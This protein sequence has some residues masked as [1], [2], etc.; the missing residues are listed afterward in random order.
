M[1]RCPEICL[2]APS[3]ELQRRAELIIKAKNYTGIIVVVVDSL[4]SAAA[5]VIRLMKA[6]I[7]IFISRGGTKSYL[8]KY[9]KANV[10]GIRTLL[11]DYWDILSR[12]RAVEGPVA[13]FSFEDDLSDEVRTACKLLNIRVKHY[14]FRNES[15]A[16]KAVRKAVQD[17]AVVAVGGSVTGRIAQAMQLDYLPL[18]NAAESIEGAL[19]TAIS[20]L[21]LQK[22]E[23]RKREIINLR[24]ERYQAIFDFTHDAI[25]SIDN[26]GVVDVINPMAEK[27]LNIKSD[28]VVGRPLSSILPA[29]RLPEVLQSGKKELGSLLNV[30]NTPVY[31]NCI[32]VIVAGKIKGAVATFQD[33]KRIQASERIIRLGLHEKGLVAKYKFENILGTS[34]SIQT[35]VKIAQGYAKSN[36]TVLIYG[37]TGTG[38]ELFAQSICNESRRNNA[39]FVAINCATLDKN[40]LESEL[41]GYVAGAF[42]GALRGGKP[43]LFELA[44]TGTIFL[45]EIGELPIDIQARLLRALQEKEIRRLGSG[46]VIPIDVRVIAATNRN[47]EREVADKNFRADLFYR[48]NVLNLNIPSL[49]ERQEDIKVL[50]EF[51]FA[52]HG[53]S[54]N[55]GLELIVDRVLYLLRDYKWPGNVREL[56]NI[57]ERISVLMSY[58]EPDFRI[59]EVVARLLGNNLRELDSSGQENFSVWER[60]RILECIKINKGVLHKAA[61]DLGISRTTLWRKMNDYGLNKK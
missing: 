16:E 57:V 23:E 26:N 6:G 40:L 28:S 60:K 20:L 61:Q 19:A 37:E 46:S 22:Q 44:H 38:K 8:N 13:F 18:E 29:T 32:P 12:L 50:A 35:A 31:A 59:N 47:L 34:E 33:V 11:S 2:I 5:E 1:E 52:Q 58:E 43:G 25:I 42:T 14:K 21:D 41:F 9:T 4:E 55:D 36:A 30:K 24:L 45:D 3:K 49:R 7:K 56:Q 39:P 15:E 17:G 53:V 54:D 10:I 48:L 51:F 27:L